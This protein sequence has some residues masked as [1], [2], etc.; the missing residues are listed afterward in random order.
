MSNPN[1]YK[2]YKPKSTKD[3]AASQLQLKVI[4]GDYD[5]RK[6]MIFWEMANQKGEMDAEGNAQ[7]DWENKL[8]FKL[9]IPDIGELLLVLMGNKKMAGQQ[10]GK[11][12]GLFHKNDNGNSCLQFSYYKT[13]KGAE[14]YN[15]R[16]SVQHG[17]DEP[18]I[19]K[20]AL[21]M[22]EGEVLRILLQKAALEFYGW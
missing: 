11:Y 8:S 12:Q 19:S 6:G 4:I 13:D 3:G 9:G 7:F 15:V 18:M 22:G 16:L 2:I 10:D 20:H 21:T 17:K 14:G 5:K 1:V